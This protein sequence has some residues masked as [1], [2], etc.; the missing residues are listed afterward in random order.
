MTERI[1]GENRN[2]PSTMR[3]WKRQIRGTLLKVRSQMI[4]FIDTFT[5]RFVKQVCKIECERRELS[6][7][8]GEDRR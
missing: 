4:N 2:M 5:H 3:D 8:I 7:F 1:M 6:P